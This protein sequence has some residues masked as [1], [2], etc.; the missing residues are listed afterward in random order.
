MGR[1]RT[2]TAMAL[3]LQ[4]S[5]LVVDDYP[6]A[7]ELTATLARRIGFSAVDVAFSGR[8]GWS[9]AQSNGYGLVISDFEMPEMNGLDLLIALRSELR[10][11]A[12]RFAMM[13][14]HDEPSYPSLISQFGGDGFIPRP[15]GRERFTRFLAGIPLG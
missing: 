6:M 15:F 5:I 8:Q 14:V 9:L 2:Q 7:A 13:S 1:V 10:L 4:T 12:T 3:N 11:K